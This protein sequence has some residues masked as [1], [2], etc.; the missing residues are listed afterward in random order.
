MPRPS[1]STRLTSATFS[2]PTSGLRERRLAVDPAWSRDIVARH[3]EG[4]PPCRPS[5]PSDSRA[6]GRRASSG[7]DGPLGTPG[8]AASTCAPTRSSR[9][10]PMSLSSGSDPV[11]EGLERAG[12]FE[13]IDAVDPVELRAPLHRS[14]PHVP[15]PT[16]DM[17]DRLALFEPGIDFRQRR[18]GEVLLGDV[19]RRR[20]THRAIAPLDDRSAAPGK[21]TQGLEARRPARSRSRS[22]GSAH[23]PPPSRRP[24]SSRWTD[25]TGTGCATGRCT[26]PRG[27]RGRPASPHSR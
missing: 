20:P 25:A 22:V 13:R 21:V 23:R 6:P 11:H 1:A 2:A 19:P 8:R 24:R 14:G 9:R 18:L 4:R 12:E 5:P 15:Q 26:R 17:G 7:R 27:Q 10:A 3:P 16:A